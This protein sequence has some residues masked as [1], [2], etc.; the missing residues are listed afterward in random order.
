[1]I[2]FIAL[3]LVLYAGYLLRSKVR[4]LQWLYL[5]SPVIGGLVALAIIQVAGR[6][7]H[8]LPQEWTAGWS[9]LPGALAYLLARRLARRRRS[10]P[11]LRQTP[12]PA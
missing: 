7:G 4:L 3:C 9:S 2:S 5:P 12:I 1:M 8:P 11:G 6:T 10:P